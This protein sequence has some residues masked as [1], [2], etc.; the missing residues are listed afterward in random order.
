[1]NYTILENEKNN[2][3]HHD[4]DNKTSITIELSTKFSIDDD[5][6]THH[7]MKVDLNYHLNAK[8]IVRSGN[9]LLGSIAFRTTMK[10]GK[11]YGNNSVWVI[12]YKHLKKNLIFLR[13]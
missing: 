6:S 12:M 11:K 4:D 13:C 9:Y 5:Y 2:D 3:N 10:G 7:R 8:K 1:M